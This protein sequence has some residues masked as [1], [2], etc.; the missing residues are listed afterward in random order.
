M[1]G[2]PRVIATDLDGTLLRSDGSVSARTAAALAAVA[3]A[4]I[5]TVL[6]TA[7][8]PR[9]LHDLS[10]VVGAHGI[11]I[12]G[13][14]AFVYDVVSR[15]VV[16]VHTFAPAAVAEV[17]AD[18]RERLPHITFAAETAVGCFV[19]ES[20]P[21][22]HEEDTDAR[23]MIPLI[24][25]LVASQDAGHRI[26]KLLA[27]APGDPT[28]AFLAAVAEV[29]GE[30]AVLAYSGAFGLAELNPPGV[31]K[32]AGL[33]RWC[34]ERGVPAADVWAFGDMPN[35]LPMLTWAGRSFAMGN[36]H[37]DVLAA[38]TDRCRTNDEDGVATVLEE[39]VEIG[40]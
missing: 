10:H 14:G 37:P 9:W 27:L 29:A 2:R 35:D 39:L 28:D 26:G 19:E 17:V 30:A 25:S 16:E 32:A 40:C 11:A 31:T 4:G 7:R 23:T 20:W 8:P 18:L 1:A 22:P 3:E 34:A 13:N 15:A 33:E 21:N 24:E 38:T 6:V 5:L 36:A 12:C